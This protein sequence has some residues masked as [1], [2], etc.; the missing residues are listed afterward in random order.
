LGDKP[1]EYSLKNINCGREIITERGEIEFYS[2]VKQW[3]RR[4]K[5]PVLSNESAKQKKALLKSKENKKS[6]ATPATTYKSTLIILTW[7]PIIT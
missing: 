5:R 2:S 1:D 3:K 7:M 4:K 6:T